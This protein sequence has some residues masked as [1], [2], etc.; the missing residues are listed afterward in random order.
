MNLS[1]QFTDYDSGHYEQAFALRYRVFYKKLQLP[2]ESVIDDKEA[3][4]FHGVAVDMDIDRVVGCVR[5]SLDDDTAQISAMVVDEDYRVKGIG[6]E[7][8]QMAINKA[9]DLGISKIFLHGRLT[10]IEFYKRHGFVEVGGIYP[11]KL[12]GVLHVRTWIHLIMEAEDEQAYSGGN[13][14]TST[15]FVFI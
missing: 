1:Y 14:A 5:L 6:S 11:S 8:L 12:T 9:R 4:A 15:G 10:A 13:F 2:V 7:L 3:A